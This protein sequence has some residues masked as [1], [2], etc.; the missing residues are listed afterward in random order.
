MLLQHIKRWLAKCLCI[1]S[2]SLFVTICLHEVGRHVAFVDNGSIRE[3]EQKL[4]GNASL[5]N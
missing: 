5:L 4:T 1:Q 2:S 3:R